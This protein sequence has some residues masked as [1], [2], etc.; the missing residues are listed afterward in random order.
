MCQRADRRA[1]T[2]GVSVALLALL[3]AGCPGQSDGVCD[4][5]VECDSGQVCARG[6]HLC[7]S[8]SEVRFVRAEWTINGQP[9][10]VAT[11]GG[12]L[13]L[14]IQFQSSLENDDFGFSP[15]PCE[16][17]SFS[18]DKLP[19]RYRAVELG[20]EGG[21]FEMSDRSSFDAEGT[22]ILDLTF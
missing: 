21:G 8:P 3:L 13:E 11:C 17:G 15:V 7:V 1:N 22:A 2:L 5:D 18:V 19:V 12:N 4:E 16:T 6:D 10:S 14:F 9:A 20:V